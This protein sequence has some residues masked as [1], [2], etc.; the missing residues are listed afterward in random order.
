MLT[1][2]KYTAFLTRTFKNHYQA[3]FKDVVQFSTLKLDLIKIFYVFY[4]QIFPFSVKRTNSKKEFQAL[5][6]NI[7]FG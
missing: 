1:E 2:A 4:K 3:Y 6:S 5:L 7:L